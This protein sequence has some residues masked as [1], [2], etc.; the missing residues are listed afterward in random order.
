MPSLGDK[1]KFSGYGVDMTYGTS[2]DIGGYY[3][4]QVHKFHLAGNGGSTYEMFENWPVIQSMVSSLQEEANMA[5]SSKCKVFLDISLYYVNS[6]ILMI[7]LD[8]DR[9]QCQF[10]SNFQSCW[11]VFQYH[12]LVFSFELD[13]LIGV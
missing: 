11:T 1:V 13:P 2:L 7:K 12:S 3:S 6:W 4:Q 5:D 8:Q 9:G 10:Y